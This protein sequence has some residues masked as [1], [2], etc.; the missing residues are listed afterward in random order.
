MHFTVVGNGVRYKQVGLHTFYLIRVKNGWDIIHSGPRPDLAATARIKR[1][2][3]PEPDTLIKVNSHPVSTLG[4]AYIQVNH[5]LSTFD[6]Y[7]D[8]N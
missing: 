1:E 5:A 8:A 4:L 7:A 6:S 3:C 2:R